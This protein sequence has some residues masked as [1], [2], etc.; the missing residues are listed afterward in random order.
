MKSTFDSVWQIESSDYDSACMEIANK[1]SVLED[2]SLKNVYSFIKGASLKYHLSKTPKFQDII[3]YLPINSNVRKTMMVRPIKTASGILVITVMA[4]PYDCPHGKCIYCPGGKEFNIPLSYTGKEPVTKLAQKF[5][6]DPKSQVVSKLQQQVLRG[7]N[8]SKVEL[9]V[10]GGTFPFMPKD[11]Q[12]NFAKECFDALNGQESR[13]LQE[14]QNLNEKSQIRC[15]GFTVET[16]PDYCKS[17]HID[18]MLELGIT[19]VEIG[20]Q[21][22]QRDVYQNI[23]RGHTIEDVYDSFQI[24]K[25]SGYKI[26]VHMMPGLPGSTPE[27]DLKDFR[28]LFEDPRLRPDMLK[29][30]PTLLLRDTGL[31]K[32]YAKGLYKPYQDD[33]LTDLLLEMKKTVPSWV[34]IMR[35]QR[36][37]E[38][39]N[40]I[41]GHSISNIR[42]I[43][44]KKLREQ[45][46]QCNCIRCREVGIRN[47]NDQDVKVDLKRFD[48][49]SSDGKEVFLSLEDSSKKVLFGYLRLRK[50]AR[51]HRKELTDRNGKPSAI[52]RELHVLGQLVDI[53]RNNDFTLSSSQHKGYGS[54]LLEKAEDIVKN[55][56][57][58]SSISII[59]AIG[60]R[61]YYKKF[62]YELNGPYVTKEM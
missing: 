54:T 33:V 11:Y 2:P 41:N 29:I 58:T 22:L 13:S 46:L 23:N 16:K 21:S 42:Q 43:L 56:F 35:I 45:G 7:H 25:D 15:V 62:G 18:L 47:V 10:V 52:V 36:E 12:R 50:L 14:A 55:E 20:V 17:S 24:S 44:Q 38:S 61:Q 28:K 48:Y 30:Y 53:G 27:K 5:E 6:F 34:R 57:A 40:I 51:P 31:A 26:V 59:S 3:K 39:E 8:V 19:R 37:I 9:V 32:L 4:K 1:L 60:T 49:D